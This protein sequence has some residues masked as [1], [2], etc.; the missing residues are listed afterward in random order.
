[1]V[2]NISPLLTD[3]PLMY[4]LQGVAASF[5]TSVCAFYIV[6]L[7]AEVGLASQRFPGFVFENR[8][9]VS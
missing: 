4:Q 2:I 8:R 9:Y 6:S 5:E 1:M 7:I 3:V